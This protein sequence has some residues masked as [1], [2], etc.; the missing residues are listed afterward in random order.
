MSAMRQTYYLLS[1][2]WNPLLIFVRLRNRERLESYESVADAVKLIW[3]AKKI[4]VLT[5]AGISK[6]AY[7]VLCM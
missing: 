7:F 5:G 4:M 1:L 3:R 2:G 6:C